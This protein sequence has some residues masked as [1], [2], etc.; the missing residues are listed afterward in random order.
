MMKRFPW[1]PLFGDLFTPLP[2]KR[3]SQSITK[4]I[5]YWPVIRT[6]AGGGHGATTAPAPL[7]RS[8]RLPL[9]AVPRYS[10]ASLAQFCTKPG[11]CPTH[12]FGPE[13]NHCCLRVPVGRLVLPQLLLH[14]ARSWAQPPSSSYF[15]VSSTRTR[16]LCDYR[17]VLLMRQICSRN[18]HE[19]NV[20]KKREEKKKKTRPKQSSSFPAGRSWH[21]GELSKK[22]LAKLC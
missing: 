8:C 11:L 20:G 19:Q 16:F 1:T 4:A 18:I 21:R 10:P 5:T 14:H 7:E 17:V 15:S 12:E 22:P 6:E 2:G 13:C 9:E 3:G